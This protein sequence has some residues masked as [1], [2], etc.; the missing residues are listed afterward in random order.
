VSDDYGA[1][2]EGIVNDM[3]QTRD[4][5]RMAATMLKQWNA[6]LVPMPQRLAELRKLLDRSN[7]CGRLRD[8][9]TCPWLR[10]FAHLEGLPL[11]DPGGKMY[12]HRKLDGTDVER[13]DACT[14]YVRKKDYIA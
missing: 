7:I 12:C 8:D 5:R 13:Y 14:G 1:Y 2:L 4:A 11:P 3:R 9:G 10:K 6:G